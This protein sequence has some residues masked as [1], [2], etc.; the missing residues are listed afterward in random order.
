[1]IAEKY[2]DD[3]ERSRA[4]GIAMGGTAA[5]TLRMCLRQMTI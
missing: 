4:M 5:G 1:M 2:P 3:V